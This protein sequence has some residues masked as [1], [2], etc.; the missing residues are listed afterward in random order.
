MSD[1]EDNL[2]NVPDIEYVSV[3]GQWKL[4]LEFGART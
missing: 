3:F 2:E 4:F 1:S